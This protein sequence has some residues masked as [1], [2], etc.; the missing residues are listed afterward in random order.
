MADPLTPDICVIGGGSAGLT[1][2]AAASQLGADVVLVE[3]AKMG[4]DCLNYGCVPSKALIAAAKHAHTF[5]ASEAF[6]IKSMTPEIDFEAVNAHIKGVIGHIAPHDSVERFEGLGVTVIED[7]AVFTGKTTLMAGETEIHARRYV[8]ATG[9]R[10]VVP[11]IEGLGDAPYL[12]NETIFDLTEKPEHLVIIGGGPIGMEMAQAYRRLGSKVTVLEAEKALSRE[13]PELRSIAIDR[14][15]AEDIDLREGVKATRVARKDGGIAVTIAGLD[16]EETVTGSHLL[17]AVGRAPNVEGLGLEAAKV[18]TTKAG[19][20]V[21]SGLKTSNRRI[22]AVG[23]VNGGPQFTHSAGY[24]GG[25]VVRNALYRLPIRRNPVI[26]PRATY[27]DPEIAWVGLDEAAARRKYNNRFKVL[28]WDY[29]DNDRAAAERRTDGLLKVLTDRGGTIIGAGAVGPLAG[30]MIA[31]YALAV[32]NRLKV[33]AFTRMVA[34][35]PTI[36]EA[37]KRIAVE[38]Y[39]DKLDNPWLLRLLKL[40]RLLG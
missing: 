19:I 25:L 26:I 27:T 8:I 31:L 16:T 12:T 37:A 35:Y 9:S 33:G 21:S 2:A 36:T 4:G 15:L 24:E 5:T 40:N 38:F 11:P 29:G 3:K 10:P 34:P 18:K 17:V 22:Y 32:A 28:R 6:G 30:E 13:D 23:D 20:K 14:V 39:R 7:E 1:V